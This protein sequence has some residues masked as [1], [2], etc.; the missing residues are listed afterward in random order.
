VYLDIDVISLNPFGDL[1]DK[2]CVLGIEL[3]E[4]SSDSTSL[5]KALSVTNAVVMAEPN[6]PFIKDWLRLT[7]DNLVD[8]PW[9][10]HAVNLPLEM[11][12]GGGY[13]VHLEPSR[14]FMP[15]CFRNDYILKSNDN[16][17]YYDLMRSYTM[18]LWETWWW[19]W[20][21]LKDVDVPYMHNTKNIFTRITKKYLPSS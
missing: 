6:H 3:S 18:H 5:S 21:G 20:N 13:D 15:F 17:Q 10:H 12:R 7:A 14:S 16:Q 1:Y 19:K 4:E 8:K 9:A 2:S 11:L